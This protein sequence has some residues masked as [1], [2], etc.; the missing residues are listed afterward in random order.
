CRRAIS[1]A[2]A[3]LPALKGSPMLRLTRWTMAHRRLVAIGWVAFAVGV[4]AISSSVGTRKANNFSLPNTGSQRATDLLTSR[5]PAQAGDA[6]QIVFQA[7]TGKLADPA[8][9]SAVTKVIA[10]VSKLP[11][12]AGVVG[13]CGSG[14]GPIPPAGT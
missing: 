5:F 14:S 3:N 2:A 9:R 4:L 12:V 8:N 10:R 13:P 1:A 11:H 6:D 7:R